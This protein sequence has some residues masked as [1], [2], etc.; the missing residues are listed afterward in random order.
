MLQTLCM[1][2]PLRDSG[3]ASES[4][5]PLAAVVSITRTSQ[6][7]SEPQTS[8]CTEARWAST[9]AWLPTSMTTVDFFSTRTVAAFS[10]SVLAFIAARMYD[11]S[12]DAF[13]PLVAVW[14]SCTFR[15]TLNVDG[16]GD[17]G[18]MAHSQTGPSE[19]N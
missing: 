4:R 1:M 2:P 18:G 16:G 10:P 19:R 5:R 9:L 11:A 15:S 13:L 3:G 7:A 8:A 6:L 17:G 14:L 12:S